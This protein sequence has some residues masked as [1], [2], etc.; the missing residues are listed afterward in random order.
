MRHILIKFEFFKFRGRS[1]RAF[2]YYRGLEQWVYDNDNIWTGKIQINT[3]KRLLDQLVTLIHELV[4][5]IG[6]YLNE[7]VFKKELANPGIEE[8][9]ALSVDNHSKIELRHYLNARMRNEKGGKNEDI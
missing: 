8:A 6:D 2:G 1:K 3:R 7:F 5:F 4:H 9:T